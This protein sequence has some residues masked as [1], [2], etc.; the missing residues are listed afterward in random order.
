MTTK[1]LQEKNNFDS[2]TVAIEKLQSNLSTA[3]ASNA[4]VLNKNIG[5]TA[6]AIPNNTMSEEEKAARMQALVQYREQMS[7]LDR[8]FPGYTAVLGL[9]K[10]VIENVEANNPRYFWEAGGGE[11]QYDVN[12]IN[13]S[14]MPTTSSSLHEHRA[15][16]QSAWD[17]L[18]NGTVQLGANF[19]SSFM[20]N[21]VQPINEIIGNTLEDSSWAVKPSV[22]AMEN[23]PIYTSEET[24]NTSIMSQLAHSD[25]WAQFIGSAGYQFSSLATGSIL[26][27]AGT[28]IGSSAGPVGSAVGAGIGYVVGA[29]V[30]AVGEAATEA[31]HAMDHQRKTK[32]AALD[33]EYWKRFNE[34]EN[35]HIQKYLE[36]N[37]DPQLLAANYQS[38][39]K[40]VLES[41]VYKQSPYYQAD[42]QELYDLKEK[43][44][45]AIDT[46]V[47]K[48]GDLVYAANMGLLMGANLLQ[49]TKI[50]KGFGNMRKMATASYKAEENAIKQTSKKAFIGKTIGTRLWE[51]ATE[52]AQEVGQSMI[53]NVGNILTDYNTFNTMELNP[54]KRETISNFWEGMMV[55]AAETFNDKQT[56]SEAMSGFLTGVMGL[57]KL[58]K[59]KKFPIG[60][61]GGL[62]SSALE[63]NDIYREESKIIEGF[64]NYLQNNPDLEQKYNT[65][66]KQLTIEDLL[67][68]TIQ[69]GDKFEYKNA[70]QLDLFTLVEMADK[71][72][73][74]GTLLKDMKKQKELLKPENEE[75]L[76]SFIKS[77]SKNGLGPY[78]TN[79]EVDLEKARE[80]ISKRIDN[81]IRFVKQYQKTR[82]SVLENHPHLSQDDQNALFYYQLHANELSHRI[83]SMGDELASSIAEYNKVPKDPDIS[84]GPITF[85]TIGEKKIVVKNSEG[86]EI[87]ANKKEI[88]EDLKSIL[89]IAED[90]TRAFKLMGELNISIKNLLK[91]PGSTTKKKEE[92]VE[93]ATAKKKQQDTDKDLDNILNTKFWETNTIPE[94]LDKTVGTI[95]EKKK[96]GEKLSQKEKDV[97][98]WNKNRTKATEINN[99]LLSLF[100]TKQTKD[101]F[102]ILKLDDKFKGIKDDD[103]SNITEITKSILNGIG[104]VLSAGIYNNP[105]NPFNASI[106]EGESLSIVLEE[107]KAEL[108]NGS[109]EFGQRVEAL[110]PSVRNKKESLKNADNAQIKRLIVD[111]I[112]EYIKSQFETINKT[113]E[114]TNEFKETKETK[115]T[116]AVPAVEDNIVVIDTT[117]DLISILDE[118]KIIYNKETLDALLE[119]IKSKVKD[120][121]DIKIDIHTLKHLV[122]EFINNDTSNS[123]EALQTQAM[124][125]EA[126]K[127]IIES[128]TDEESGGEEFLNISSSIFNTAEK[129]EDEVLEAAMNIDSET[130]RYTGWQTATTEA[131]VG[132]YSATPY[133]K[134]LWDS[135]FDKNTNKDIIME[136]LEYAI[137]SYCLYRFLSE[138]KSFKRINNGKNLS[139]KDL[140][141]AYLPEFEKE[142]SRLTTAELIQQALQY[143]YKGAEENKLELIREALRD[144]VRASEE[145]VDAYLQN[146]FDFT[147]SPTLFIVD[148]D[149][150]IYGDILNEH[151]HTASKHD[152]LVEFYKSKSGEIDAHRDSKSKEP[153]IVSGKLELEEYKPG[154]PKFGNKA[155][156]IKSIFGNTT[157]NLKLGVIVDENTS[158]PR[159]VIS[160]SKED[161]TV[162]IKANK[163]TKSK[164]KRGKPLL[165]I[166]QKIPDS[167][168]P[169]YHAVEFVTSD[170]KNFLSSG[171]N[172]LILSLYKELVSSYIEVFKVYN[173]KKAA[174]STVRNRENDKARALAKNAKNIY[175]FLGMFFS[176]D[177][178]K[179]REFLNN[180]S[181]HVS[182]VKVLEED[183]E[184]STYEVS[185]KYKNKNIS[186]EVSM[187]AEVSM[188]EFFNM[189]VKGYSI[190]K[191]Y[192]NGQPIK[193]EIFHKNKNKGTATNSEV[194]KFDYNEL[195][196]SVMKTNLES[197]NIINSWFVIKSPMPTE[198]VKEEMEEDITIEGNTVQE[199]ATPSVPFTEIK[200]ED[201]TNS[202]N[203]AGFS[204]P[205]KAK[206]KRLNT[207]SM[208]SMLN[209]IEV[210]LK[211]FIE[212]VKALKATE[213]LNSIDS[214][215]EY[216]KA[217]RGDTTEAKQPK[218]TLEEYSEKDDRVT[219]EATIEEAVEAFSEREALK[220]IHD[221][222][223][224]ISP[225]LVKGPYMS[226]MTGSPKDFY[227]EL[228]DT[229]IEEYLI[230]DEDLDIIEEFSNEIYD[231]ES[232]LTSS[233]IFMQLKEMFCEYATSL[234]RGNNSEFVFQRLGLVSTPKIKDLFVAM[235]TGEISQPKLRLK[236]SFIKSKAQR[237]IESAISVFKK[238]IKKKKSFP[239][240]KNVEGVEYR[241]LFM[242]AYANLEAWY[243]DYLR[244]SK[245]KNSTVKA[246]EAELN[247]IYAYK[248][249]QKLSLDYKIVLAE[250]FKNSK[251]KDSTQQYYKASIEDLR[252]ISTK[253]S[254][255]LMDQILKCR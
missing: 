55:S 28:A 234:D 158:N 10:G 79:G 143:F 16:T 155:R 52:S 96:K 23:F 184:R 57:P 63:A 51:G 161:N 109:S 159:A 107:F 205:V 4:V 181:L 19:V 84:N 125:E 35:K 251:I 222:L 60:W 108:E 207:S 47:L 43:G 46:D 130:D 215:K 209:D 226:S 113:P 204:L 250:Y 188:E 91:A 173:S 81:N 76:I 56:A 146:N 196:F 90:T 8:Q 17:K 6:S 225:K 153:L 191:K 199:E 7:A 216:L 227:G 242:N 247:A 114:V 48:Q 167:K 58:K 118:N 218:D 176:M 15:A 93:K 156:T 212:A 223:Y 134:L 166:E 168:T 104:N 230:I 5:Q 120:P 197:P 24:Y 220:K 92:A 9:N 67:Y 123:T 182:E 241:E 68:E 190:N 128:E 75:E 102:K 121:N 37:V 89:S 183:E 198:K 162:P 100:K 98:E 110:I 157:S 22:K 59:G 122:R 219:E 127:F 53:S 71:T 82:D 224:R 73:K 164:C 231:N 244:L 179:Y 88:S 32:T 95:L 254:I 112:V 150:N 213:A 149:G 85:D 154:I 174:A 74:L 34:M 137:Q 255:E 80:S 20:L 195:M 38:F 106:I 139:N 211:D 2:T 217:F 140:Y 70:E 135:L 201:Y 208:V 26:A 160:D 27:K 33:S 115:S 177:I 87:K 180:Y 236:S 147:T 116:E 193:F 42:L 64:N 169:V 192:V 171:E 186:E 105:K 141:L 246:F 131:T 138:K 235:Y 133:A 152:G 62:V 189:F 142:F 151:N 41:G 170:A 233:D 214:L 210:P 94:G 13:T 221:R 29:I 119:F 245:D 78:M 132:S 3:D 30:G 86:K 237:Q 232:V 111:S 200:R 14:G 126:N 163:T 69:S 36:D 187:P 1:E 65:L 50:L 124:E 228:F 240:L 252:T 18:A 248:E 40:A 44:S 72:G 117:V 144:K 99:V 101:V 12:Y 178:N 243:N 165:L 136:S 31:L 39:Y 97:L 229:F 238:Y 129:D 21:F 83:H 185:W 25:F 206:L 249:I 194:V 253:C 145:Q 11:S 54:E 61:S 175:R 45:S 77:A 172:N 66:V 239:E 203:K 103:V 49:G 202:V 148:K